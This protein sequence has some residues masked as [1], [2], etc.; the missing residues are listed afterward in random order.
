[1]TKLTSIDGGNGGGKFK[2][3]NKS[4]RNKYLDRLRNGVARTRSAPAAGVSYR[5]IYDYRKANPDFELEEIG[6]EAEAI[7]DIEN[8]VHELAKTNTTA[9][10]FY[11][12][13]KAPED[14]TDVYD[15]V[16]RGRLIAEAK[17][18]FAA[19]LTEAFEVEGID[20]DVIERI[21]T[22]M[23]TAKAS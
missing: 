20:P 9:A 6:A 14:W 2:K 22:K 16:L 12:K 11:L 10:I 21:A 13:N 8:A 7:G 3:F 23:R 4:A 18:Q 19:V 17:E 1:M 15:D 5:L